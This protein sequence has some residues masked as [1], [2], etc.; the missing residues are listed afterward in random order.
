MEFEM[1]FKPLVVSMI[2]VLA[3]HP[4][5]IDICYSRWRVKAPPVAHSIGSR[6]RTRWDS[7]KFCMCEHASI[8]AY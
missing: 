8:N 3:L 6:S 4:N 5:N 2:V 7:R 1:R